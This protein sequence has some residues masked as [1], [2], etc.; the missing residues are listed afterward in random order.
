[1]TPSADGQYYYG[2]IEASTNAVGWRANG[3]TLILVGSREYSSLEN[4]AR[5]N[6][7]R[8]E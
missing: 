2:Q 1:M 6:F 8:P 7:V 4:C 3:V 5:L